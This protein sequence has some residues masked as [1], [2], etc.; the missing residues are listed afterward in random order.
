MGERSQIYLRYRVKNTATSK[1]FITEGFIAKYYQWCYGERMISR[2]RNLI[3]TVEDMASSAYRF[4]DKPSIDKLIA[5]FNINWDMH[6]LVATT[7]ILDE[8]TEWVEKGYDKLDEINVFA[9]D[10]NHGQIFIDVLAYKTG[11]FKIKYAFV[12]YYN[13]NVMSV[14]EFADYDIG[15]GMD[16][17]YREEAPRKWYMPK[18]YYSETVESFLR[19]AEIVKYT[20]ANIDTI[21]RSA[22]LMTNE[23]K[24]EFVTWANQYGKTYVQNHLKK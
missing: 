9:Q 16:R 10:N 2:C 13:K 22:T 14:E 21:N 6:D 20:K 17:E 7:D 24:D 23:E 15:N 3:E 1:N 4:S 5:Q 19:F 11:K 18:D 8:V 12:P